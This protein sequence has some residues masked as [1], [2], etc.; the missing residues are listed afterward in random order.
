MWVS[1]VYLVWNIEIFSAVKAHKCYFFFFVINNISAFTD[2]SI[3]FV[4]SAE[5]KES[6]FWIDK[7]LTG[8]TET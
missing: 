2:W 1:V 8:L 7:F 6:D 3:F 5:L 4:V